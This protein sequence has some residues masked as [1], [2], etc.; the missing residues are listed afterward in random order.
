MG[1]VQQ[2][3]RVH[4]LGVNELPELNEWTKIAASMPYW[5][6]TLDTSK[7]IKWGLNGTRFKHGVSYRNCPLRHARYLEWKNP[8]TPTEEAD[9]FYNIAYLRRYL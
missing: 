4:L 6:W 9:I 5:K 1:Y 7:P 3:P 2:F 8:L